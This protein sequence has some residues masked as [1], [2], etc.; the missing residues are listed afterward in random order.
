MSGHR[1]FAAGAFG[2]Q[3]VWVWAV[4][5]LRPPASAQGLEAVR[6]LISR[7]VAGTR[8][9]AAACGEIVPV[10]RGAARAATAT[11]SRKGAGTQITH[12]YDPA[13]AGAGSPPG[14]QLEVQLSQPSFFQFLKAQR[15]LEILGGF[16]ALLGIT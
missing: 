8:R 2:D 15:R 9:L 14:W 5:A 16:G 1:S 7:T 6:R 13:F 12:T 3:A 10:I 4:G 11:A